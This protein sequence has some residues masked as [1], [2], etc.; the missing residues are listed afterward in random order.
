MGFNS[1]EDAAIAASLSMLLEVSGNPK[2]GN[3]DREHDFQDLK[4]EDFLASS[5]ASLPVFIRAAENRRIG[6]NV[7]EAVK[8]TKRW[9][10]ASNVHFGA[11]LLLIPLITVW[12]EVSIYRMV[13]NAVENLKKTSATDS[14]LVLRAF[15]LCRARIIEAERFGLEDRETEMMLER[16]GVN[17]YDWMLMAPKENLI[18]KE[19]TNGYRISLEGAEFIIN[20]EISTNDRIV[21]LYHKLLSE[22]PDPLIIS[23]AGWDVA[24]EVKN[25]AKKAYE[26][27]SIKRF[28]ELD[29]LLLKKG[30]NPG[31]IADLVVSSLYLAIAEGW[32]P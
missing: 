24:E 2:A 22:Y 23:K 32:R 10:K 30:L 20:S 1:E 8:F 16:E 4:Y 14:L 5:I 15:K 12:D 13:E 27:G 9:H 3:V 31:T 19:L 29:R 28:K 25:L 6:E 7:Y 26:D 17:L 21:L 11:F 18:A